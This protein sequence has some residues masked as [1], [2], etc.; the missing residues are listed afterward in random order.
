MRRRNFGIIAVTIMTT[1]LTGLLIVSAAVG[2]RG[3][4][5]HTNPVAGLSDTE[6]QQI[7]DSAHRQEFEWASAFL[8][9]GA[10]LQSLAPF[11]VESWAAP[12]TSL[13]EATTKADAIVHGRVEKTEFTLSPD[14]ALPIAR[15][16]V[17]VI[18]G[19]KGIAA[20]STISVAQSGGPVLWAHGGKGGLAYL[21]TDELI[22]GHGEVVL[23]LTRDGDEYRPVPGRGVYFV[24]NDRV[25]PARSNTAGSDLAGLAPSEVLARTRELDSR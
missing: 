17:R 3:G 21:E 15:S 24:R 6:K 10:D 1:S 16:T 20:G 5:V 9:S 2:A 13:N 8:A 19:A 7:V 14:G 12:V 22:A 18:E 4:K 11:S 25:E 23:W